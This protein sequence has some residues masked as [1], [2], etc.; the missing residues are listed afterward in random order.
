M[1]HFTI[2]FHK[3]NFTYCTNLNSTQ[4]CKNYTPITTFI[5]G[6]FTSTSFKDTDKEHVMHSRDNNIEFMICDNANEVFKE[7]FKSLLNR[8]EIWLETSM[9]GSD[10]TFDCVYLL[11]YKCHKVIQICDG[12]YVD[13][14]D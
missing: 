3:K 9:I 8:Y 4:H 11:C 12:P 6:T 7:L 14:P 13:S 1:T 10:F 2:Q 5:H